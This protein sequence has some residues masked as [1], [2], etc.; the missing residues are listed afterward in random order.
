MSSLVES[1]RA[2]YMRYRALAEA[3]MGQLNDDELAAQSAATNN[4]IATICW[5][6]AGNF[7]SRFSD[8]LTSDD[9]K[10]WRRRDEE[11]QR[12][13]PTRDEL[14]A[15]WE[16]GWQVLTG[17]LT[18]LT[19]DDL[20]RTITIRRQP[21][22]VHE[23]LHRSLAHAAYHVGQIVYIAKS[24]RGREW[25]SLSIPPGQSDTYNQNAK[26]ERPSAHAAALA[27]LGGRKTT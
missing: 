26:S 3:A 16:Q 2:E 22:A 12:R 5:H 27:E 15:K 20:Q 19:D 24:L 23:A 6:L 17:A 11:F 13:T 14:F 7:Q 18:S 25:K 4:S 10:P 1:I 8:F 21:M 9:E